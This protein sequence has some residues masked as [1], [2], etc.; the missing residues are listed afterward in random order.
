MHVDYVTR[1]VTLDPFPKLP[2]AIGRLLPGFG[3]AWQYFREGG[4]NVIR[5][6]KSEYHFFAGLNYLI[7]AFYDCI[8][9]D[10]R[11]PVAYRDI[12]RISAMTDEIFAQVNQAQVNQERGRI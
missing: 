10:S 4:R 7:S 3:Q 9:N 8:L 2:S 12:L 1:T 5:F 11:P 6:A